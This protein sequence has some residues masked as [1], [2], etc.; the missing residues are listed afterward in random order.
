MFW[1]TAEAVVDEGIR[2]V[3]CGKAVHV[4]GR[5]NRFGKALVDLLP[6]ALAL[7]MTARQ[8]RRFR[9]DKV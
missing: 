3:E 1:Q 4:T 9:Q 2:A 6:D 8:A 7:R 5:I